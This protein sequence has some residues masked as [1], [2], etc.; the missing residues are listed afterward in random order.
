[1]ANKSKQLAWII[2]LGAAIFIA[3]LVYSSFQATRDE[4]EV[5][6]AFNGNSHCA[7]ASGTNYEDAV[8]SAQQ[9]DCE[10]LAN[11]RDQN[12]ACLGRQPTSIRHVTGRGS[13]QPVAQ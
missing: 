4:Y 13:Q 6:M 2:G 11:G 7:S 12:M 8:R 9:I 10:L 5:C 3:I 1:M